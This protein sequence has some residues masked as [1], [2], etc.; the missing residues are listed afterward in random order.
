MNG[1]NY[2]HDTSDI[3]R[4]FHEDATAYEAMPYRP[5]ITDD[6]DVIGNDTTAVYVTIYDAD[7]VQEV[8]L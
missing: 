6:A 5:A 2:P 4:R 3:A 8:T 7:G 1:R